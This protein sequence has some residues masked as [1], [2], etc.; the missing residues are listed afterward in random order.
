MW[1]VAWEGRQM[2]MAEN[3][4]LG[5]SSLLVTYGRRPS[6]STLWTHLDP[7][8]GAHSFQHL[9][10]KVFSGHGHGSLVLT[11]RQAGCLGKLKA[12]GTPPPGRMAIGG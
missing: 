2:F 5:C 12:L 9:C 4:L 8:P 11:R 10:L 3:G 7:S 6:N 1:G